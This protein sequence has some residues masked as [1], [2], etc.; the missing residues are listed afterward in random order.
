MVASD[1]R[2]LFRREVV[3]RIGEDRLLTTVHLYV[4]AI[5]AGLLTVEQADRDKDE[6]E[7]QRFKT[8]VASFGDLVKGRG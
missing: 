3:T 4:L 1:E 5:E 2:R 6:L 7:R 8:G